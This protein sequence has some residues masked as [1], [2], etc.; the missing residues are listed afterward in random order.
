[1]WCSPCAKT[2][3]GDSRSNCSAAGCRS[4]ATHPRRGAEVDVLLRPEGLAVRP[5]ASTGG[6]ADAT[7][8]AD[9]G[10]ARADTAGAP[11]TVR[12]AT[13]L[14]ATT[15]LHLTCEDGTGVKADLPSWEAG[16]L[17]PGARCVLLPHDNPVL[18][19]ERGAR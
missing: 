14:G 8:R 12:V 16:G 2:R 9:G 5:E 15:R 4:T 18:V 19:A 3:P 13:F 17:A 11:A 7:A 10:A 1:M 6:G